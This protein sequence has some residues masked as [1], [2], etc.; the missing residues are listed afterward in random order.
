MKKTV[1]SIPYVITT[2]QVADILTN[3]TSKRYFNDFINKLSIGDV[4]KPACRSIL[5]T[6]RD[7]EFYVQDNRTLNKINVD[8]RTSAKI[9]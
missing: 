8:N 4:S 6:K 5:R 2:N 9:K 7:F 3:G 1:S